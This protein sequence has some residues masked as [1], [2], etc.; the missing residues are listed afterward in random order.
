MSPDPKPTFRAAGGGV[1]L[2]VT[3]AACGRTALAAAAS[4]AAPLDPTSAACRAGRDAGV[5][6]VHSRF[7][8]L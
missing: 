3:T 4:I 7:R 8:D 2:V 1:P 5:T 6:V